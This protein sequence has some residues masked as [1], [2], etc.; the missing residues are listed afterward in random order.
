MFWVYPGRVGLRAK[1]AG[2]YLTHSRCGL[3]EGGSEEPPRQGAASAK[4][5][6]CSW[7]MD[8]PIALIM[9]GSRNSKLEFTKLNSEGQASDLGLAAIVEG[10]TCSVQTNKETSLAL[11]RTRLKWKLQGQMALESSTHILFLFRRHFCLMEK[12]QE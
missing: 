12:H 8:C 10:S 9:D 2:T 1:G 11:W 7:I 3:H 6:V 4:M 5:N